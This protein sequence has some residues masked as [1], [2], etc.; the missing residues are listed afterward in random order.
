MPGYGLLGATE[1]RGLLPW[2]WAAERLAASANYW[3]ATTRPD[4]RPHVQAVWGVWIDDR[5]WFSTGADSR[6]A[7][8]LATR[9][10]CVV[11]TE[12]GA[13]PVVVEGVAEAADPADAVARCDGAYHAKYP[14][15]HLD[16]ALGP[17]FAVRPIVAF[18]LVQADGAF[19]ATATRWTFR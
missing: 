12:D 13:E 11:T 6:K 5:L 17:I 10:D 15:W 19:T 8:N 3:L 18:G 9:A 16:P 4:G 7:R 14:P 1:G 2:A